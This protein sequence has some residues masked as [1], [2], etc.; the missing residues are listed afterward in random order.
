MIVACRD[1]VV[2]LSGSLHKNQWLTIK[3]AAR[4]L[5]QQ[6]PEGI[7]IDCSEL[8]DISEDGAK[9]FLEAMRDIQGEGARIIVVSLPEQVMEVIRSVPGVRSQLPIAKTLQEARASFRLGSKSGSS[10]SDGVIGENSILVPL[11]PGLDVEYAVLVAARLARELRANVALA[12]LLVVTRNRPLGTP[13]PEEEETALALL[14]QAEQAARR[15]SVPV[16]RHVERVRDAEEGV[17]QLIKTYKAS[18]VILSVQADRVNDEQFL[19]MVE[20][21]LHRAP[22]HVLIARRAPDIEHPLEAAVGAA[23]GLRDEG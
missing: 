19:K 22:C 4:L 13:M 11:I 10:A 1:D 6:H 9:T 8:T 5:L 23:F 2:Q 7:L 15:V 3:A 12:A 16:V 21:L 20:I 17:L 14:G 18:H